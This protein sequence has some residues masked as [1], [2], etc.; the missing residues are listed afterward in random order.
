MNA[1]A[2]D[3]LSPLL[4]VSA[5]DRPTAVRQLLSAKASVNSATVKGQTPVLMAAMNDLR[6][7]AKQLILA[8]ADVNQA[9]KGKDKR[10]RGVAL[11]LGS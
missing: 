7:V 3:G 4:I 9:L 10:K 8:N 1:Q 2:L 11:L 6:L 5:H